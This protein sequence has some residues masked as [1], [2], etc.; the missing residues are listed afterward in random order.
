MDS[1]DK[2]TNDLHNLILSVCKGASESA[3]NEMLQHSMRILNSFIG[4][5]S[6]EDI[7]SAKQNTL[8]KVAVQCKLGIQDLSGRLKDARSITITAQ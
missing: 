8:E 7:G 5:G 4:T 2:R 1:K 3:V 6:N